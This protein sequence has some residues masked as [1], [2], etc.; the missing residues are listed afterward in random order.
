MLV[1]LRGRWAALL[2][3]LPNNSHQSLIRKKS[4]TTPKASFFEFSIKKMQKWYIF[5]W[6][7]FTVFVN[8]ETDYDNSLS[9]IESTSYGEMRG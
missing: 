9:D 1:G 4:D 6:K 2:L 5:T 8:L 3:L 7:S